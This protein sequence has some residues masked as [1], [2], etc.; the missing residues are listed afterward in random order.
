MCKKVILGLS[1]GMDSAYTAIQLAEA[2]YDV[3]AVNIIMCNSCDS[4]DDASALAASLGLPFD[5]VDARDEF[6][7]RVITPFAKAYINGVTPNPCVMCNPLVKLKKLYDYMAE[8][9]GDYIAT[10]HYATPVMAGKRWSFAPAKD[11]A[12]DQG[13]FL[14]YYAFRVRFKK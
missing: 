8:K 6:E 7:K 13:Y 12:K 14:Y 10:G 1:G 11:S 3:T 5:V 2:G 4:S 9:G